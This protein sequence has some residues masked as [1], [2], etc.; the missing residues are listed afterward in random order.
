MKRLF[1]LVCL[2]VLSA[3]VW[4]CGP[5]EEPEPK[6]PDYLSVP[7]DLENYLGSG[8]ITIE[9]DGVSLQAKGKEQLEPSTQKYRGVIGDISGEDIT[10]NF[11]FGQPRPYKERNQVPNQYWAYGTLSIMRTITPGTYRMGIKESPGPRGEIAD[12][13]LNLPGPQLY[14]TNSGTLTITAS[15]LIRTQGTYSLYRIE[16]TFQ[17]QMYADGVGLPAGQRNPKVN[18][19]FDLLLTRN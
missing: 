19:K 5:K 6:L 18:G 15:T 14:V 12:L 13:I 7:T 10:A 3:M 4:N 9:G 11:T 2:M 8:L 16:G 17:A 1:S